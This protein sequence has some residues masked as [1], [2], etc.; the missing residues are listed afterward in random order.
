VGAGFL[1]QPTGLAVLNELGIR[2]DLMPDI[3]RIEA[4]PEIRARG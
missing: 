1:L 3:A 2:D 4:D